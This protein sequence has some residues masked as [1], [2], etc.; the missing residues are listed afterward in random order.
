MAKLRKLDGAVQN[1]YDPLLHC[2]Q[3]PSP[4]VNWSFGLKGHGLPYGY[5]MIL[6][7]PPKGG[8]SIICNSLIGQLHKD[9]QDAVAITFNTEMRGELQSSEQANKLF[10]IDP[11]RF[12]CY[13]VNEP[14]Q[15]FDRIERDIAALC[16]DGLNVKL[17]I[18]DSLKAIAGRRFLNSKSVNQQQIGD[19][20]ATLQD[21]LQRIL[22]MIRKYKIALVMTTHVRAEMDMAEQ[23]RGKTVKMAAAFA[24]RHMAEL[25]CYVEP[26]RSKKGRTTLAGEE[27]L[28]ADTK[29]FMEKAA[30]TGHKIRFRVDG[31]SI[32]PD[33]RTAEFTLDYNKGIIN[34]YEEIFMLAKNHGII[35]KP[36]NV[37]YKFGESSWRGLANCLIAIR[38]DDELQNE[39][40]SAVYRLD[41]ER[42]SDTPRED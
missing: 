30:K 6:F 9:E 40:L 39:L 25:F 22:P 29:D 7:G 19:Q 35:E 16:D 42:L 12:V 24:A 23:M 13:D 17:I 5:S 10:G 34:Q 11:D 21:G 36:N 41:S 14:D 33:G 27:F 38:D 37:T 3:T 31:N 1:D 8:K 2:L 15:I 26:N 4:S 32:G 18:I 20:A 28:D